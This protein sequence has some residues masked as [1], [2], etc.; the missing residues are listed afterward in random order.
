MS[1]VT[2]TTR[3]QRAGQ[4]LRR[5]AAMTTSNVSSEPILTSTTSGFSPSSVEANFQTEPPA[6][7]CF[8][9]SSAERKI[10]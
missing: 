10:G 9:A 5:M 4:I 1:S 8:S 3:T 2:L 6:L 7:Q